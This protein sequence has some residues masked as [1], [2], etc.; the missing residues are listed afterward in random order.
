MNLMWW[1]ASP[2][3]L[4]EVTTLADLWVLLWTNFSFFLFFF[5]N[6]SRCSAN[7]S[8]TQ[9]ER[10]APKSSKSDHINTSKFLGLKHLGCSIWNRNYY[11]LCHYWGTWVLEN[12]LRGIL[13]DMYRNAGVLG[14]MEHWAHLVTGSSIQGLFQAA[15]VQTLAVFRMHVCKPNLT[16]SGEMYISYQGSKYHNG[17]ENAPGKKAISMF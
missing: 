4:A 6:F 7:W 12:V 17:Y 2:F 10:P 1:L 14:K 8:G 9:C 11:F 16:F 3:H 13:Q 15:R 5:F